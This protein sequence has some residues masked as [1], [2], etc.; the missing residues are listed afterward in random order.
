MAAAVR[1]EAV[2]ASD[3]PDPA[4]HAFGMHMRRLREERGLTLEELADRSRLSFRGIIY[5][6]HGRRNPSLTTMLNLARGLQVH[7]SSLLS[8]F[9]ESNL[10][11][12]Q[13]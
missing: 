11:G 10:H 8:I 5:I 6:E 1:V 3:H 4:L 2:P 9:D 13:D 7:P 12:S